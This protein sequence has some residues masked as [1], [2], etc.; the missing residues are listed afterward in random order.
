MDRPDRPVTQ[1]RQAQAFKGQMAR[2]EL[3]EL[4][5]QQDRPVLTDPK[6]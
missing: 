1:D 5:D 3:K 4:T 6:G 2:K